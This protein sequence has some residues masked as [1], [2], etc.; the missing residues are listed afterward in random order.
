MSSRKAQKLAKKSVAQQ[1]HLLAELETLA[2]TIER[3]EKMIVAWKTD[4]DTVNQKHEGRKTTREDVA[5]LEDLLRCAKTKLAWENKME[6]LTKRI[7]ALLA[8]VSAMMT[9]ATNPPTD[10]T[11]AEVVT[12][13]HSVQAAMERLEKAKMD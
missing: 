6:S 7:P 11:R 3:S 10:E 5:Y 9:D 8:H 13:L 4:M 1:R 12:S 2:A